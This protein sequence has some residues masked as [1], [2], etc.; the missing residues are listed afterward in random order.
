MRP[1]KLTKTSES[2]LKRTAEPEVGVP[3]PF[4]PFQSPPQMMMLPSIGTTNASLSQPTV[5]LQNHLLMTPFQSPSPKT[6]PQPTTR[7]SD[8]NDEE[9]TSYDIKDYVKKLTIEDINLHK[10]KLV[11]VGTVKRAKLTVEYLRI[12][13]SANKFKSNSKRDK[14]STGKRFEN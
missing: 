9:K 1:S 2:N 7:L 10:G 4:H 11:S 6:I 5:N 3:P 13:F 14:E 12:C 8:T